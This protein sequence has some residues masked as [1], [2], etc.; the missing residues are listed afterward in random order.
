MDKS[1]CVWLK[2]ANGTPQQIKEMQPKSEINIR[3]LK[4]VAG[5]SLGGAN[6]TIN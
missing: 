2:P 3:K 6:L 4:P 1:N 5:K